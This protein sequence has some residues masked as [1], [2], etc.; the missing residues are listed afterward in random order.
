M[1]FLQLSEIDDSFGCG[2]MDDAMS[3]FR[4]TC[5]RLVASFREVLGNRIGIPGCAFIS[6][7][8][9]FGWVGLRTGAASPIT[10]I[11]RD[12]F[13]GEARIDFGL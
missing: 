4:N 8:C 1:M 3:G 13:A 9:M 11:C 12:D 10:S 6:S 7:I 5:I 2:Q